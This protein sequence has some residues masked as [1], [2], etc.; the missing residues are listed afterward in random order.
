MARRRQD[1]TTPLLDW[2]P[3]P[4]TRRYPDVALKSTSLATLLSKAVALTLKECGM[5][6]ADVAHRMGEYLGETIS[7]NMLDN[8]ASEARADTVINGVR[9][10]ALAHITNDVRLLQV[11]AEPFGWAVID[12]RY[13]SLI[14]AAQIREKVCELEQL[15]AVEERRAR[16]AGR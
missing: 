5:T 15:A 1:A 2:Q 16:G 4:I 11:M 10:M 7:E 13:V 6:R 3:P 8:Y 12:D 9:I 14:R